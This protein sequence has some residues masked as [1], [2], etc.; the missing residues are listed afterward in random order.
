ME[1][2]IK[3]G[4]AEITVTDED[5]HLVGIKHTKTLSE[6]FKIRGKVIHQHK[7]YHVDIKWAK[8]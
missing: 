8:H 4:R 2:Q 1:K 7:D 3:M 6:A 5:G